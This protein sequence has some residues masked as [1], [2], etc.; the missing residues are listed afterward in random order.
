MDLGDKIETL[1][2]D[3]LFDVCAPGERHRWGQ[4]DLRRWITPTA[5]PGGRT[6]PHF[7]VLL[8]NACEKDCAYC[9][10][11]RGRDFARASFQAEE[12]AQ[13]FYQMWRNKLVTGLFLSSGVHGGWSR[14]MEAMIATVEI[15]RAKHRFHGYVHLKLMPAVD[16][17]TVERAV[18]LADRVS[19]NLE[20][21]TPERLARLAGGKDFYQELLTPLRWVSE[22]RERHG[23]DLL[24]LGHTTQ[25]VVGASGETDQE[26]LTTAD[27]LYRELRLARVYY[28]AFR[29]IEDT[30]L[31]DH[32]PTP[33][34]R[35]HRLYQSDLLLRRYGFQPQELVFDER[36]NLP[37]ETDPKTLLAL[38]EPHRFPMEINLAPRADLLRVPGI[39]PRAASRIIELRRQSAFR[40]LEDLKK[41]G[42]SAQ[43]AAPFVLLEGGRPPFQLRLF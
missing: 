25:L 42:A 22:M 31:E 9:A 20:A 10:N 5:L 18:Q 33:P 35:Q 6:E 14:T 13:A 32:P 27:S 43:R 1:A 7:K 11:R 30:P 41:V 40:S 38:R 34:M 4:G 23:A 15:L 16:K 17:A 2:Q 29:P 21:P 3:A 8:S 37:L 12:L 26:I 19:V 39:G 24:P 36:G 28:S